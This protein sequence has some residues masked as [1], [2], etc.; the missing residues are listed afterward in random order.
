[1]AN[2]VF[3]WLTDAAKEA[4][5]ATRLREI[6][7]AMK[8]PNSRKLLYRYSV[9]WGRKGSLLTEEEWQR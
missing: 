6:A 7:L 2:V 9:R 4:G 8:D 5:S 3:R 1:M